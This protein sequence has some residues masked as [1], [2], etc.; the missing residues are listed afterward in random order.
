MTCAVV[1]RYG[2][3][4]YAYDARFSREALSLLDRGWT[5]AIA[6][7]RYKLVAHSCVPWACV[8]CIFNTPVWAT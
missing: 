6:H 5:I 7:V 2:A 1:C 4:G 8:V 3:Y